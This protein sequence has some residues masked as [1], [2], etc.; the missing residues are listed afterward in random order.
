M[1]DKQHNGLT[2]GTSGLGFSRRAFLQTG[3]AAA[4]LT[5]MPGWLSSSAYAQGG[6]GALNVALVGCGGRGKG[7]LKDAMEAA[8]LHGVVL[9]CVAVC[10]YFAERANEVGEAQGV[11]VELRFTGP[12]GYQQ[13]MQ[14]DA[15]LVILATP[16]LFRPVHL[17]AAIEAGKH[18]FMEKPAAVDPPGC[19]KVMSLGEL[20]ESKGLNIVAGTQR[21]HQNGYIKHAHAIREGAIGDI[22]GGQVYW[23]QS[24]LW[25]KNRE[26]NDSAADYM[27][28]NW[29]SF[30][31]MSGD[32]IV[33]QHVHQID[34]ANWFIG[35][36][37]VSAVGFGSRQRRVTGNM[38]DNFSVEFDYGDGCSVH[39]MC[40]QING[41]YNKVDALF[42]G[43]EGRVWDE[44]RIA[45]YD[46]AEIKLP[47]VTGSDKSYVQ[48]HVALQSAIINGEKINEAKQVA[49]STLTAIM[50]RISAY[51]GQ[52]V[53]WDDVM[54]NKDSAWYGL[55]LSP[56][57]DDFESGGVSLPEEGVAP[58][59]G[60]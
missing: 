54:N 39:S 22:V 25:Y 18:V 51:T 15:D 57:A 20:A 1:S 46:K 32:H 9:K 5:M 23:C 40:R 16:P 3:A 59:P 27:V 21:R 30:L 7:A 37:P 38:Y 29:V 47:D 44:R 55:T 48:E 2:S 60:E 36:H 35:R 19:R 49:E 31:E 28:R 43:T 50:G 58:V 10:D 12:T 26:A 13:L 11:P 34:V 56:S 41:C 53:Q 17:A 8:G 42:T 52:M 24:R 45:R 33:E 6:D 14:T 4:A